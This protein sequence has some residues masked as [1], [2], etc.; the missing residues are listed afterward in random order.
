MKLQHRLTHDAADAVFLHS[1]PSFQGYKL[2]P[3][4][5]QT[6]FKNEHTTSHTVHTQVTFKQQNKPLHDQLKVNVGST[7]P[8]SLSVFMSG[9]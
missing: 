2:Q 1:S 6:I 5:T 9:Y 4:H 3:A 8:A 7:F